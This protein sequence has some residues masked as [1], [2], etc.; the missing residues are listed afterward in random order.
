MKNRIKNIVA[1]ILVLVVSVISV[2]NTVYATNKDKSASEDPIPVATYVAVVSNKSEAK[3]T[4]K[5]ATF[6]KYTLYVKVNKA[7]VRSKAS[8]KSKVVKT[9]YKGTKVTVINKSGNWRQVGK[10]L[11]IHKDNLSSKDPMGSYKDVKLKYYDTYSITKNKLTRSKGVV[12]YNGHKETWYS[13]KEYGQSV[14]AYKIP[15]KHLAKDGTYRD[16]NGYICIAAN[17]LSK[18]AVIMT[19][20]G[21]GKVYD[22]GGMKG[23]WIDIY[24]NW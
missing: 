19:S 14:T 8:S 16:C 5:P 2:D 1:I 13:S 3:T 22:R 10:G 11:W 24:T 15:G 9:Y 23:Q 21:P 12:R 6:K 18:G 20:L 4:I 7:N 17:Y